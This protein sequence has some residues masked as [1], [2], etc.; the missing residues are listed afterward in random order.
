MAF[1]T[2]TAFFVSVLIA[3]VVLAGYLE[4]SYAR[5]R[6][7]RRRQTRLTASAAKDQ[8]FNAS[9]TS[10]AIMRNLRAQGYDV[11]GAESLVRQSDAE[12]ELGHFTN[13]KLLAED[14]RKTL[15]DIKSKGIQRQTAPSAPAEP[16]MQ[17]KAAAD[18]PGSPQPRQ[19]PRNYAE[20]SFTIRSVE[21]D[22]QAGGAGADEAG[23]LL[24]D[25][26]N[27]FSA[28]DYDAALRHAV[29]ASRVLAAGAGGRPGI[30]SI[31]AETAETEVLPDAVRKCASCGAALLD[32]DSFCRKCGSR[33]A[34]ACRSCGGELKDG[35]EYCGRCG[36]RVTA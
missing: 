2:E 17:Q 36:S 12:L 18:A 6:I 22:L 29:R 28:G 14:A 1:D 7:M 31:P 27:A 19:L 26:R 21:K 9:V 11:T 10:K 24:G 13:A 16:R 35:D 8:A 25:A 20:A 15:F 34:A 5:G 30:Q 33:V 3:V 4:W 32:G 23:R